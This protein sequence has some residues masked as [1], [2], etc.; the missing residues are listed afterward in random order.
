MEKIR[1]KYRKAKEGFQLRKV[2]CPVCGNPINSTESIQ[3]Y[4]WNNH[5]VLLAECWSGSTCKEMPRHTFLI[6]IENLP[7]VEINK[8]KKKCK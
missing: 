1:Y 6:D 2:K 7:I 4:S 8:V 3:S 5:V